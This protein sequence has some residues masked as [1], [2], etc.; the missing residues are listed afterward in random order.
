MRSPVLLAAACILLAG[1]DESTTGP[2]GE[3]TIVVAVHTS[4]GDPDLDG[5]ELRM[6]DHIGVPL[7]PID[8]QTY[9][10][11]AGKHQFDL[12][13]VAANCSVSGELTRSVSLAA[14]GNERIVFQVSCRA[15]GLQ[16]TST[17]FGTDL[18]LSGYE[19]TVD[20]VMKGSVAPNG[21]IHISRLAPGTHTV[22]VAG[23]SPNCTLDGPPTRTLTV[24]N[25]E[26]TPVAF[27]F[28]CVATYGVIRIVVATTGPRPDNA[29]TVESSPSPGF[30]QPVTSSP[31]PGTGSQLLTPVTGV[32][33][34][35]LV[36]VAPHCTVEG[37][38][39][40]EVAV[41][42]GGTVRD[43]A[44]ARFDIT[45]SAGDA[46]LQMHMASTGSEIPDHFTID[47]HRRLNCDIY[48]GCTFEFLEQFLIAA[49]GLT[50]ISLPTDSYR[51]ALQVGQTCRQV[52]PNTADVDLPVGGAVDLQFEVL[53]GRALLRV[54]APTTGTNP[55]TQYLVTVW[56]ADWYYGS[57]TVALGTLMAGETFEARVT[58]YGYAHWVE[59][60]GVAVNCIVTTPNPGAP[61]VLEWNEVH[62]ITFPV[63]CSP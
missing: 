7:A 31:I 24:T 25:A 18:D 32:R 47:V 6:D 36:D 37:D 9:I 56:T 63:T 35:R 19:I 28:T 1:C 46:T 54:S 41:S 23:V 33:Y 22:G 2:A 17:S 58:P 57:Y 43:T 27:A 39:L 61:F 42:V 10:V 30:E 5:Y 53:C 51:V 38:N 52:W 48:Y 50:A 59:L 44:L 29:L 21:L 49:D 55:D 11:G 4:G 3:G 40:L 8:E 15:T 16:V 45:C 34:L 62:E 60:G 13:G 26:L 12:T 20:G 14:G